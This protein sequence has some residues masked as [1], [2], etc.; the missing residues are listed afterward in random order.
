MPESSYRRPQAGEHSATWPQWLQ[1][2]CPESR[3]K[4]SPGIGWAIR[5]Q[6]FTVSAPAAELVARPWVK[7]WACPSMAAS[8]AAFL[9]FFL[10]WSSLPVPV[11]T[12][13][14]R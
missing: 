13:C 11:L 12:S 5:A 4:S 9:G 8:S 10:C 6:S 2:S 7:R 1:Q 14:A 3:T